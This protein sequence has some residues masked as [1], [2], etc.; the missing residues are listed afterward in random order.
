M[1]LHIIVHMVSDDDDIGLIS[2]PRGMRILKGVNAACHIFSILLSG[3]SSRFSL[4]L[5]LRDEVCHFC[6]K[7]MASGNSSNHLRRA[8][9][10]AV[11]PVT[12]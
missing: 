1:A 3:R 6:N 11:W 10:T 7:R 2:P 4:A 5:R 12:S 9:S 8:I